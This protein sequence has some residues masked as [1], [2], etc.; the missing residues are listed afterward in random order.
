[1][2][3]EHLGPGAVSTTLLHEIIPVTMQDVHWHAMEKQTP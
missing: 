3:V 2:A 1:M